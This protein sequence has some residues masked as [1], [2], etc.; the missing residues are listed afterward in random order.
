MVHHDVLPQQLF[1]QVK[2]PVTR[3]RRQRHRKFLIEVLWQQ[4]HITIVRGWLVLEDVYYLFDAQKFEE[5][6]V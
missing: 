4:L 2:F 1:R 3:P 6:A 5:W